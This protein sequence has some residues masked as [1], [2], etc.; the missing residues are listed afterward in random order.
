MGTRGKQALVGITCFFAGLITAVGITSFAQFKNAAP[1]AQRAPAMSS[2]PA[3]AASATGLRL[4]GALGRCRHHLAPDSSWSYRE[5][6]TYENNMQVQPHCFQVGIV[7]LPYEWNSVKWG[8]RA[9][10][11]DLGRVTADNTF[12][13]DEPEYFRAKDTRT[14]INSPTGRF[15]GYGTHRGLT[16]GLAA[17]KPMLG[18][19]FGVEAGL[20]LLRNTWHV[21]LP[22]MSAMVGCREDW[23]CAD[24]NQITPY[25]GVNARYKIFYVSVRQYMSVHASNA[26]MN[27]PHS[28]LFTGPTS[29][30]VTQVTIGVSIP[31]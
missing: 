28:D 14:P 10:Y 2:E 13:L 26:R 25:F 23:A 1:R 30:P 18:L 16:L 5:W 4:E 9:A 7:V 21:N 6:G 17:E 22:G 19:D 31:L 24:G 12:P 15:H 8:F 11:V 29:G 27:V 3:V 20:A